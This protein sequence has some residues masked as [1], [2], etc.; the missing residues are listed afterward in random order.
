MTLLWLINRLSYN[1]G[2]E[3]LIQ[4]NSPVAFPKLLFCVGNKAMYRRMF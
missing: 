3:K 1:Q 4:V 2:R